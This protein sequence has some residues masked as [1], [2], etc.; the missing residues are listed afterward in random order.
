MTQVDQPAPRVR[1]TLKD[2]GALAGVSIK[3][4]S[5]VVNDE[6]GVSPELRARVQ[7][8]ADQLDYRQNLG[9]RALRSN[10]GRTLAVGVVLQDLGNHFSSTL[11]RA[12]ED[13]LRPSGIALLAASQ[14]EEPTL[15]HRIVRDLVSRRVDALV[16]MA[17]GSDQSYLLPEIRAGLPMVFVDRRPV[18]VDVDTVLADNVGGARLGTEHLL[19]RGHRRIAL[20]SDLPAIRTAAERV[21]GYR[22]AQ[23][24]AGVEVDLSLLV[25]GLRTEDQAAAAAH[26]L[27]ASPAP[28]TA[29]FAARNVIS[30]GVVRALREA[31]RRDIAVVGF[32]DL[33]LADLLEPGLTVVRQDI[34]AIGARAARRLLRRLAGDRTPAERETIP[35]DLVPRGSGELPPP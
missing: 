15:E 5:R 2:V 20:L 22:Q 23:Q 7:R 35:C 8:A 13:E 17:A 16:L 31:G 32:D 14:D 27:V 26:A 34:A 25:S 24:E 3:T 30:V 33:P 9:A 1:A 4:V 19:R 12:L 6:P 10:D 18:G 29:I 21:E 11:L 28:P